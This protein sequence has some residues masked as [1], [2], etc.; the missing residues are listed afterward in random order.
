MLRIDARHWLKFGVEFVRG[1]LQIGAV[2]TREVSD[3]Y[4]KSGCNNIPRILGK[5]T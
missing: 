2:A 3:E 4:F 1:Q 5:A